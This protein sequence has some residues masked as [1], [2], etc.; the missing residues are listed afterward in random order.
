MQDRCQD[1]PFWGLGKP[2]KGSVGFPAMISEKVATCFLQLGSKHYSILFVILMNSYYYVCNQCNNFSLYSVCRGI[3]YQG[4]LCSK[5]G[6]GAHKECLGRFGCCGKTGN[7]PLLINTHKQGQ[8]LPL[9]CTASYQ[10]SLQ[11]SLVL[12]MCHWTKF[13]Q[14]TY[15]I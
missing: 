9:Y 6:L 10:S 7:A 3:F 14:G 13:F 15:E 12:T 11:A 5:C 4:Y 1:T 2:E 8:S